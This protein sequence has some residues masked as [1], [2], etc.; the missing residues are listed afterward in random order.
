MVTSGS[1]AILLPGKEDI[2]QAIRE[3]QEY[4]RE[5]NLEDYVEF[6]A[7]HSQMDRSELRRIEE[8]ASE[9]KL[10]FVVAT[11]IIRSSVTVGD[12]VG[13]ID[14]LQ[15][16]RNEVDSRG[17]Q[18]LKK[19]QI[20]GAQADQ[21]MGRVGRVGPG[22]YIPISFNDEYKNITD[23]SEYN[24]DYWPIPAIIREGLSSV[25]L[26]I[27][28]V[29]LDIRTLELMDTPE[30]AKIDVAMRRL[31]AI[32]ALDGE[33]KITQLGR[34]LAKIPLDPER[35]FAFFE[36]KKR[37][38]LPE[39]VIAMAMDEEEGVMFI[40]GRNYKDK[41]FIDRE[42]VVKILRSKSGNSMADLDENNLPPWIK[43]DS[44]SKYELVFMS[45]YASGIR[46]MESP[47][48]Y[49]A[50][51]WETFAGG[52]E[53]DFVTGVNL[54]RTYEAKIQEFNGIY[55]HLRNGVREKKIEDGL[56]NWC[57]ENM[58]NKK[59]L[60]A[61]RRT[62]WDLVDELYHIEGF[63]LKDEEI[64]L[65]RSFSEA[66]MT[67][68]M[69]PGFV[70][71]LT[72]KDQ[73][74]R[75]KNRVSGFD[76]VTLSR[77][78]VCGS[79]GDW[80]LV[81]SLRRPAEVSRGG[82]RLY[83][84]NIAPVE[85]A[86]I[87]EMV[88][89]ACEKQDMGDSYSPERDKAGILTRYRFADSIVHEVYDTDGA[90]RKKLTRMFISWLE[91]QKFDYITRN[92]E[93]I[94]KIEDYNKR[95]AGAIT[96]GIYFSSWMRDWYCKAVGD[97]CSLAELKNK[98]STDGDGFLC[99]R[100]DDVVSRENMEEI[101]R[102]CPREISVGEKKVPIEYLIH[103][104]DSGDTYLAN[105]MLDTTDVFQ[106]EKLPELG[107]GITLEVKIKRPSELYYIE[108]STGL[109]TASTLEELREKAAKIQIELDWKMAREQSSEWRATHIAWENFDP[110]RHLVVEE[111]SEFSK[112]LNSGVGV[113]GY[114]ASEC[115][116]TGMATLPPSFWRK[117]FLK[118][119]DA[120]KLQEQANAMY[121]SYLQAKARMEEEARKKE[122]V[123]RV[124]WV[125]P[126][127]VMW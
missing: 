110:G 63:G 7:C 100:F 79:R 94:T 27:A 43:S 74:G 4:A 55:A 2:S 59:R 1:V 76:E 21:G 86:W 23:K 41:I 53:S 107:F 108:H 33:G 31:K 116:W 78:S 121:E 56:V 48:D 103:Y 18:H 61:V 8:S 93:V 34:E 126:A 30:A 72:W 75:W 89:G 19:V 29:G 73:Y 96:G 71:Y 47:A 65:R 69:I 9:G 127:R 66:E 20:S 88:P 51:C 84:S 38:V 37:G 28:S 125:S 122:E 77:Q 112:N 14:S 92:N 62:V 16:K 111:G 12:L 123:S 60:E 64:L 42:S 24:R 102:M 46:N 120:E 26:Q 91:Y 44:S 98:I 124:S 49:A 101:D 5:N 70:D 85:P 97:I 109:F 95:S 54:F 39:V 105:I 36:A 113:H 67:K 3:L 83:G 82:P 119:E 117:A 104:K 17:V 90:D 80:L 58:I 13:V 114:W 99:L 87:Y 106:V 32:N 10:R 6:V 40:P 118:R 52:S 25:V 57:R 15:V 68:S 115:K 45:E 11:E 50:F 22:F 81:T 35:A